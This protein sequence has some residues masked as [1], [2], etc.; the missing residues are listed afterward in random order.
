MHI[1]VW[2][3][4]CVCVCLSS[5]HFC[6]KIM[7]PGQNMR[8]DSIIT[9]YYS[10]ASS[11]HH[12][13]QTLSDIYSVNEQYMFHCRQPDWSIPECTSR[14]LANMWDLSRTRNY[15]TAGCSGWNT[16][17]TNRRCAETGHITHTH[18]H[19]HTQT[20][21]AQSEGWWETCRE[22]EGVFPAV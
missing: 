15:Q 19:T 2:V 12:P 3:C 1:C 7:K 6:S 22:A 9:W 21:L 14:S 4:V 13:S 18:T 8:A 10:S 17:I 20:S 11:L 5:K 16:C